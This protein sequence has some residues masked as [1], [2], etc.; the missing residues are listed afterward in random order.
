[1]NENIENSFRTSIPIYILYTQFILYLESH[2]LN[3]SLSFS[4]FFGAC[5]CVSVY[6][7]THIYIL[8]ALRMDLLCGLIRNGQQINVWHI[9]IYICSKL[10]RLQNFCYITVSIFDADVLLQYQQLSQTKFCVSFGI[11]NS[12]KHSQNNSNSNN[13][14]NNSTNHR[15]RKTKRKPNNAN[16]RENV[17]KKHI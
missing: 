9:Y 4:F 6:I 8:N 7:H 17:E 12:R 13:N 2:K 14:D 11:N 10:I 3:I 1:M 16:R 15:W 5:M